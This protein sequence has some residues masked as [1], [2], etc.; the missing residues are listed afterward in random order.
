[1]RSQEAEECRLVVRIMQN[2]VTSAVVT[3]VDDIFFFVP[4]INVII[5][6]HFLL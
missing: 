3:V 4:L 5:W 2:G 6:S 1:V